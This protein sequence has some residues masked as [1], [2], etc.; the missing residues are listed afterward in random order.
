MRPPVPRSLHLLSA[1]CLSLCAAAAAQDLGA[2]V[3]EPKMPPPPPP[4][5]LTDESQQAVL[6]ALQLTPEEIR[7]LKAQAAR[8]SQAMAIP[9]GPPPK[10]LTSS[11]PVKLA[12]GHQPPTLFLASGMVANATF[13]DS[14]GAA[15][16]VER[17]SVSNQSG[18]DTFLVTQLG[19]NILSITSPKLFTVGNI[20]IKFKDLDTPITV[21]LAQGASRVVD[22]NKEFQLPGRG[23]LAKAERATVAVSPEIE[24]E[25]YDFLDG[26]PPSGAQAKQLIGASGTVWFY[27]KAYYLK[28]ASTLISPGWEKRA[29]AS[30]GTTVYKLTPIPVLVMSDQGRELQARIR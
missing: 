11:V 1:V 28:T 10:P 20:A 9:P 27:K 25:M 6:Q 2:L 8:A 13:L 15:W 14:T 22:Y 30:D 3:G 17:W 5:K 18:N 24:P 4:A 29:D 12:P 21:T 23:P 19:V 7:A 16:P 26:I